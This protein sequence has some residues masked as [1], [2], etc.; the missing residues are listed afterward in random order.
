MIVIGLILLVLGLLVGGL[1][2]LFDLGIAL[3]VIGVL[4]ELFGGLGYT[5]A[6]RRHWW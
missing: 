5:M 1:H 6:G 4:L 2:I 3:I